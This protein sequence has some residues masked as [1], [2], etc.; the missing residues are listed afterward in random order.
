[1]RRRPIIVLMENTLLARETA[2]WLRDVGLGP[3]ETAR[4]A[5]EA[6]FMTGSGFPPVLV[7][8]DIMAPRAGRRLLEHVVRFDSGRQ[9]V[10]AYCCAIARDDSRMRQYWPRSFSVLGR[11]SPALLLP[12]LGTALGR[13]DLVTRFEQTRDKEAQARDA[14]RTMQRALL[15]SRAHLEAIEALHNIAIASLYESDD[16]VGGDLWGAWPAGADGV[17]V[18]LLDF[19][20][21]GLSAALNT[22]RIHVLLSDIT[23]PHQ[24]PGD[25]VTILNEKLHPLLPCGHYA[26]L[27]HLCL[28]PRARRVTWCGAGIPYPLFAG[29]DGSIDLVAPGLPL[30]VRAASQYE[31]QQMQLPGPGV[32]AV[33]SDGLI[34]CGAEGAD[35]PREAI[36][37]ALAPSA[38]L[39]ARGYLSEAA[40]SGVKSL[41]A[42][43]HYYPRGSY[44][45]DIVAI[46]IAVGG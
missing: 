18:A 46:C 25:I 27:V 30:G 41:E 12:P 35:I 40:A 20:G 24:R 19:A 22:F 28:D 42:L 26:C 44:A 37:A 7:I 14:A 34:E 1:M 33:F 15:P 3:V 23:M 43:R 10:Q 2:G 8:D 38:S 4:S 11:L 9:L 29:A 17:A 31:Q 16:F 39:A 45:D 21:H 13:P 32:L 36:A 5:D 6:I